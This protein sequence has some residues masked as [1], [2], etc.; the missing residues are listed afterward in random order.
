MG[1]AALKC[2]ISDTWVP[3]DSMGSFKPRPRP[4]GVRR[5]VPTTGVWDR[6]DPYFHG[7]CTCRIRLGRIGLRVRRQVENLLESFRVTQ[8]ILKITRFGGFDLVKPDVHQLRN[9]DLYI[10]LDLRGR[11]N[12]PSGSKH[13]NYISRDS[14]WLKSLGYK[15]NVTLKFR[16]PPQ[17]KLTGIGT[18]KP[19]TAS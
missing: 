3:Q 1:H 8:R 14:S 5:W 6:P 15:T 19:S 17:R 4:L 18:N 13:S 16:Q 11:S 9:Y 12:K 7:I 10:S 2:K